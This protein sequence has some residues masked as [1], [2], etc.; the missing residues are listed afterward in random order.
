MRR[1]LQCPLEGGPVVHGLAVRDDDRLEGQVEQGTQG[2]EDSFL[3]PGRPSDE[4][5]ALRRREGVGEDDR[6]LFR[7]PQRRVAFWWVSAG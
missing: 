4:Q 6:A 2:R 3:V 1:A 7:E 5:V